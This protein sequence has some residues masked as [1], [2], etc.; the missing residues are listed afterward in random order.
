MDPGQALSLE[1]KKTKVL[2]D[3]LKKERQER[4]Q[5]EK[6]FKKAQENIESLNTQLQDKVS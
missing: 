5:I 3:A 2:K 1:R 4:A 6:D